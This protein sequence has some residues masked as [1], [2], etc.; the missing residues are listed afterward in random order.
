MSNVKQYS[1]T[2]CGCQML[3]NIP[4]LCPSIKCETIFLH[5]VQVLNVKQYSSS[6]SKCLML[7]NIPR[8]SASSD[9]QLRRQIERLG[10]RVE[11][12][13]NELH[14]NMGRLQREL[15]KVKAEGNDA[16]KLQIQH[17]DKFVEF[18]GRKTSEVC[19]CGMVGCLASLFFLNQSSL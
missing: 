14:S 9:E 18:S 3:N 5:F 15:D 11:Q 4:P 6:L 2:L 17:Y 7:N 10:S 1:S 19:F 12:R 13:L 8:L 16:Q